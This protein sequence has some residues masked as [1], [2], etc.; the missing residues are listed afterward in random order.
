MVLLTLVSVD[1][2]RVS[3]VGE[4]HWGER[5]DVESRVFPIYMHF[6]RDVNNR[7]YV[8][9]NLM[10][11]GVLLINVDDPAN[12]YIA[13]VAVV[14]TDEFHSLLHG[15][16]FVGALDVEV[17]KRWMFIGIDAGGKGGLEVW[18]ISDGTNPVR[19]GTLVF[20]S[21]T[22][23]LNGRVH[24]LY[25][26][27]LRERL[28]VNLTFRRLYIL[29]I[30]TVE[31]ASG[32]LESAFTKTDS[33][34]IDAGSYHH[35]IYV[36]HGDSTDTVYTFQAAGADGVCPPGKKG[37][38][39]WIVI[40]NGTD[41]VID[42][43]YLAKC[44]G[45]GFSHSG[46]I[47]RDSLLINFYES[48]G[49]GFAIYKLRKAVGISVEETLV[50]YRASGF[51]RKSSVH[52]GEVRG[53]ILYTAYYWG[54][55]RIYDISDPEAPAP[56][57]YYD[58]YDEDGSEHAF[59]GAS[60]VK[61]KDG[62]IYVVGFKG[63]PE[64]SPTTDSGYLYIF[65]FDS[66]YTLG[67]E[68]VVVEGCKYPTYLRING[69]AS[70]T[71]V[72]HGV[73][74]GRSDTVR[75]RLPLGTY[76]V[77]VHQVF[78]GVDVVMDTFS[79][80]VDG[81]VD[82]YTSGG[83][84]GGLEY[85]GGRKVRFTGDIATATLI[86]NGNVVYLEGETKGGVWGR[87]DVL[88]RGEEVAIAGERD[89]CMDRDIVWV[90]GD[91]LKYAVKVLGV[92]GAITFDSLPKG[93]NWSGIRMLNAVRVWDTLN[94]YKLHVLF[95]AD[96][97]NG[98]SYVVHNTYR[99]YNI[100]PITVMPALI[101]T[102]V[103][104]EVDGGASLSVDSWSS[105]VE[106]LHVV[107]VSNDTLYYSYW[108]GSVWRSPQFIKT[109]NPGI[110][111]VQPTVEVEGEEVYAGW[112]ERGGLWFFTFM[113]G[114][115]MG[116]SDGLWRDTF[117]LYTTNSLSR[118]HYGGVGYYVMG[119]EMGEMRGFGW[120]GVSDLVGRN[121]R[122]GRIVNLTNSVYTKDV[123]PYS[124]VGIG[125][126]GVVSVFWTVWEEEDGW[127]RRVRL[128]KR[129]VSHISP[130]GVGGMDEVVS[131]VF[132][133]SGVYVGDSGGV[134]VVGVVSGDVDLRLGG[135]SVGRYRAG[136]FVVV[137]EWV[138][139][140]GEVEVEA[141]GGD[142]VLYHFVGE[143]VGGLSG[144]MGRGDVGV[145]DVVVRG[146]YIEV[147]GGGEVEIYSLAGRRLRVERVK[148]RGRIYVGDL[149]AG[150]YFVRFRGKT[151]KFLRR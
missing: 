35:D 26:D 86:S 29:K 36:V 101:S 130:M 98:K 113:A 30:D 96:S 151:F 6:Y 66:S 80:V 67:E 23:L 78:G 134:Y 57:G 19:I 42:S 106:K 89:V 112:I 64:P 136:D 55:L 33:V 3:K 69:I 129:Y 115:G 11:G 54:G 127:M 104:W 56:V 100:C 28:Y 58:F 123:W 18:D 24:T 144:P 109:A 76:R 77:E 79:M 65:T 48:D 84:C 121:V 87:V 46:R 1:S 12:P 51:G 147:E 143:G 126:P 105:G 95:I 7:E 140:D 120:R 14:D 92:P 49:S 133:G 45:Y 88:G 15:G 52:E 142:V 122:T 74:V 61:L 131:P 27:S 103:L 10:G 135:V 13:S 107:W 68:R 83:K 60:D 150:V 16:S 20:D 5:T 128:G 71:N 41:R 145:V 118:V 17:F 72:E 75:V 4:L 132:R 110:D 82:T 50:Y 38:T 117:Q 34:G 116:R 124:K 32:N 44:S 97:S 59:N 119:Y 37:I 90:R 146:D 40:D 70:D 8:I 125:Y 141:I 139:E 47:W 9:T 22:S 99:P 73:D 93:G 114:M 2:L 149:P 138:Y 43:G 108:N 94:T 137:P 81:V 62:Y 102:E 53:G 39:K 148:G 25:V 85:G 31:L 21:D 63:Y 91:T 111:I